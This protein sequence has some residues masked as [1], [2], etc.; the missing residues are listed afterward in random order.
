MRRFGRP[1][2][3]AF[4]STR[5]SKDQGSI[6]NYA[7]SFVAFWLLWLIVLN[8]QSIY[9]HAYVGGACRVCERIFFF[10]RSGGRALWQLR[11]LLLAT[12]RSGWHG[13]NHEC[14]FFYWHEWWFISKSNTLCSVIIM[15]CA[16]SRSVSIRGRLSKVNAV[17]LSLTLPVFTF[18]A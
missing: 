1:S 9:I 5:F 2:L 3:L 18:F 6:L 4:S 12:S 14:Y 15:R 7:I 13:N 8:I 17:P 10:S 11:W 16:Y